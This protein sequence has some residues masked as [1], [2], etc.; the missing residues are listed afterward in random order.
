MPRPQQLRQGQRPN[1][2]KIWLAQKGLTAISS[3]I[4]DTGAAPPT[5]KKRTEELSRLSN[6]IVAICQHECDVVGRRITFQL[7]VVNHN[8]GTEPHVRTLGP[9]TPKR[10]YRQKGRP[11]FSARALIGFCFGLAFATLV[12]YLCR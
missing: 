2:T 12:Q 9:F 6:E 5:E 10:I 7:N 4:P 8:I 1:K 11:T 3:L